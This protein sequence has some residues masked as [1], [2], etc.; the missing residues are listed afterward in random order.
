MAR[1]ALCTFLLIFTLFLGGCLNVDAKAP[2]ITGMG[3]S[4]GTEPQANIAPASPNNTADLKRENAE[5]RQRVE[6][7]E[8]K[9]RKSDEKYRSL[10]KDLA[11]LRADIAKMSAERDK[12]K[13][14]ANSR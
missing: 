9:I 10:D 12:Y 11:E 4:W 5:L 6:W 8:N 2:N 7:L 13:Q 14:A 1:T 3:G